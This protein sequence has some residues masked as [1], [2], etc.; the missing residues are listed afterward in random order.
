M[1]VTVTYWSS[2]HIPLPQR[3]QLIKHGPEFL[4][5][6]LFF[7][8]EF[9]K[10]IAGLEIVEGG[11]G[12]LPRS[13]SD[14]GEVGEDFEYVET[15]GGGFADV[16]V[17]IGFGGVELHSDLRPAPG[18]HGLKI[19]GQSGAIHGGADEL[20]GGGDG[21]SLNVDSSVPILLSI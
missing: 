5:F 19:G 20:A 21:Q 18:R 4:A 12:G 6:K 8:E 1:V 7:L 17:E 15:I 16:A 10:D 14:G 11:A 2:R 9:A 13:G 3:Q